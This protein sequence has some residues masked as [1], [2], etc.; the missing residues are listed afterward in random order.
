[1][2]VKNRL[3]NIII[4]NLEF[5]KRVMREF[6]LIMLLIIPIMGKK[7]IP[8]GIAI[9]IS[10]IFMALLGGL[11]ISGLLGVIVDTFTD[12]DKLQ[13]FIV[14]IEISVLGALLRQYK[15]IDKVIEYLTKIVRSNRVIMM[16]IPA[17]VGFL[18]VPG[19]A[20]ISAP[21]VDQ[22]GEEADLSKTHRAIIN[23]VYRH[24]AT[25]IMPYT[26]SFL[27]IASL[28]PQ[29]SIYKLIGLNFIFVIFLI[30]SGYFLYVR[31]VKLD[32]GPPLTNYSQIC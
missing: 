25:H 6:W 23:L 18:T 28:A 26:T 8:I 9:C 7:E 29:I 1:M 5:R 11:G 24:I 31:K 19:G 2:Q 10:A 22:L 4:K 20:I 27:L 21:F 17:L 32:K 13:Q 16:F 14:I 30:L 3:L 12:F 15:I